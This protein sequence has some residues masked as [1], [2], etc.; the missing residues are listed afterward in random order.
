MWSC[1]VNRMQDNLKRGN[2]SF[3]SLRELI[4]LG[5]IL[6]NQYSNHEE[7]TSR[8]KSGNPCYHLMQN[9]RL[10]VCY[11]KTKIKIHGTIILPVAL[12][13]YEIWFCMGTKFGFPWV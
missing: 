12:H 11:R 8:L 9:F 2:K 13:G 4:Y 10:L 5:T 6:T 7:V 3:D 1:H